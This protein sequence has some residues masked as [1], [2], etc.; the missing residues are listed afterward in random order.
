MSKHLLSFKESLRAEGK[1]ELTIKSYLSDM[2]KFIQWFEESTGEKFE[3]QAITALDVQS[4]RSY[5]SAIRTLWR[6]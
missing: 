4:Y 1:S 5:L 2:G 6:N 3:P